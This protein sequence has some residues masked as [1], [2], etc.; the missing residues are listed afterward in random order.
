MYYKMLIKWTSQKIKD[1]YST[2]NAFDFKNGDIFISKF[3][4]I[5]KFRFACEL[6]SMLATITT[7]S[8][9]TSWGQPQGSN[10]T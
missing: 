9:P 7:K 10:D 5:S 3:S 6:T 8:F 1:T 2:H 4:E